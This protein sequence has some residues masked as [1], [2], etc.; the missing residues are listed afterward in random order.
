MKRGGVNLDERAGGRAKG[1]D[2]SGVE[3]AV[4]NLL[5]LGQQ[6]NKVARTQIKL[7]GTVILQTVEA[8]VVAVAPARLERT[9][10]VHEQAERVDTLNLLELGCGGHVLGALGNGSSRKRLDKRGGQVGRHVVP[11]ATIGFELGI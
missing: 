9:A 10:A 5:A 4:D 2:L 8:R 7:T 6:Q 3:L 1:L 11:H